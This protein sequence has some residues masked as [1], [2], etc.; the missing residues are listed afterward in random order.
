M[1]LTEKKAK[2]RE[3][4]ITEEDWFRVKKDDK[5]NIILYRGAVQRVEEKIDARKEL[6]S[7][8]A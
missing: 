7:G 6:L 3:Y 5:T 2:L 4:G 1:T 8:W